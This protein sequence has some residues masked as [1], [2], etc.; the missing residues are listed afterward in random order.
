MHT[1][2]LVHDNVVHAHFDRKLL[3]EYMYWPAR[4]RSVMLILCMYIPT[5]AGEFCT[6]TR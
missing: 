2:Q 4:M 1:Q 5:V 6:C 3:R